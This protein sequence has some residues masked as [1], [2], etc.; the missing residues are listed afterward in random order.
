MVRIDRYGPLVQA[1]MAQQRRHHV[2]VPLVHEYNYS[3]YGFSAGRYGPL[4][5]QM[6]RVLVQED[7]APLVVEVAI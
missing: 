1:N 6:D 5:V 4:V 3:P 7:I 2:L